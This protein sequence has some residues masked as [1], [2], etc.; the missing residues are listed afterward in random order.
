MGYCILYIF[1]RTFEAKLFMADFVN[2]RLT[3]EWV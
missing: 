3:L 1:I 2:Q